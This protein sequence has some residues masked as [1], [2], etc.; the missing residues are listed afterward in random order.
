VGLPIVA[1]LGRPNV[2]KST[3]FNRLSRDNRAV[4]DETPGVTR[5]RN[6]ATV[7][8]AGRDFVIVDTGGLILDA[9]TG[10]ELSITKQAE[11]A[12]R[13]ADLVLF[14]VEKTITPE[15]AEIA[16]TLRKGDFPLILVANKVDSQKDE[17]ELAD[18]W[19]LG[20]GE[21][22]PI[23]ALNGRGVADFLD[24]LIDRL[25]EKGHGEEIHSEIRVAIVGK[26]NVG[27]SSYVN[28]LLGEDKLVVD[29]VPGTTRDSIDTIFKYNGKRWVLTDTA[30]L[31]RKQHGIEYYSSLRT[32]ST[33]K[34]SD[35]VFQLTDATERFSSQDKRIAGMAVDFYK[36]LVIGLNKW[37]LIEAGPRTSVEYERIIKEEAAFLGFAPFVTLSALTGLRVRKTLEI[38]EKVAENR[39][40]RV[41]T[42]EMNRFVKTVIAKHPPPIAMG[43]RANIL[44]ATQESANPPVI[45]FFCRGARY[46]PENYK[47][48]LINS[49]RHEF[50]FE[51]VSIKLVFRERRG[52]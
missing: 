17:L 51:G 7:E 43:K 36:G 16:N 41:P 24:I 49:L 50:G 26:P 4:V 8:W 3:L 34:R 22:L 42:A 32:V 15:D 14:L 12:A 48:Y 30:G 25:P 5:D 37:D 20:L 38:L 27:K 6:Y 23:S 40:Q 13:E 39:A 47:R 9:K 45:V 35:I 18:I 29:A 19:R 2:G 33:I 46:I 11:I 44:Y 52:K 21:F 10:I 28:K 1:I 31:L